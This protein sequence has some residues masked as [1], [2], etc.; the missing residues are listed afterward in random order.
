VV[1]IVAALVSRR[2]TVAALTAATVWMAD[3]L[4]LATKLAFDRPRPFVTEP[5]PRP[6]L[7]GVLGDSFPSAHAATSFAGAIVLM[8]WIPRSRRWVLVLLAVAIAFSRIYVG[9][10]YPGDVLAGG[11]LGAAVAIAL[12]RLVAIRPRWRPSRPPG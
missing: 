6:L 8:R 5:T 10:H 2:A 3:A 11:A 4:A 1:A 12:P 9:V 7:L